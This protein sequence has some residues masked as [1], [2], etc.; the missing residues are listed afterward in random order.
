M[1]Y[2]QFYQKSAISDDLIE[3][4]GDRAVVILDGRQSRKTHQTIAFEECTKRGY[5]AWALYQGE[6]FTR[7]Y[8]IHP[9]TKLEN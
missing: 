4:C 5:L 8:R 2:V 9:I 6:A 7:S 3:A 1:I